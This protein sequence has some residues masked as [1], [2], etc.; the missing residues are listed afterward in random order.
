MNTLLQKNI[1]SQIQNTNFNNE[2]LHTYYKK[3]LKKFIIPKKIQIKHILIQITNKQ[4]LTTTKTKTTQIQQKIIINPN[5]FK[6]LTTK[7]SKNPYKQHNKNLNFISHK[8][9]PNIEPNIIKKTFDIKINNISKPFSTNNNFNIIYITN[10]HK[11]IKQTFQQI[12]NSILRKLKNEHLQKIYNNY[13]NKLHNNIKIKIDDTKLANIEIK[14]TKHP[15]LHPNN[16]QPNNH[17]KTIPT[18]QNKKT[19]LNSKHPTKNTKLNKNKNTLIPNNPH[20]PVNKI[21]Q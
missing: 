5:N 7:Y 14:S 3:H 20:P 9:K 4:N 13:I 11:K 10:H 8:N 1:Y 18:L 16:L 2:E 15:K 6:T 12:K 17:N 19:N 21:G